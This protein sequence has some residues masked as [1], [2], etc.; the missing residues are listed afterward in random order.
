MLAGGG[1]PGGRRRHRAARDARRGDRL[2]SRRARH[3]DRARRRCSI[4]LMERGFVSALA[5]NGAG[6]IHDFE[7]ALVGRDVGGRRRGARA[8]PVRHGRGDRREL[9]APSP[10]ASRAGLGLGQSVVGLPRSAQ[11]QFASRSMLAAAARLEIPVTVH[12]AHRHRHHS[13]AS[14]RLGR[15]HRRGEPARLPLLRVVRR[16]ARAAACTSIADPR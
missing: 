9:N 16:A 15:G 3:Q 14:G 4:D 5:I 12:V 13:H 8:R 1:F 7:I 2:G 6:I 10:T 11:P